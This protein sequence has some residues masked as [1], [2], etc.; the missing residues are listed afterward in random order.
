M[1]ILT[2]LRKC[3]VRNQNRFCYD[4]KG[5]LKQYDSGEN[6]SIHYKYNPV[7]QEN[8]NKSEKISGSEQIK[9]YC[10]KKQN[11]YRIT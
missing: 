2:K 11:C 8:K 7:I 3:T 5:T 9:R 1:E 6:I 4:H 10:E